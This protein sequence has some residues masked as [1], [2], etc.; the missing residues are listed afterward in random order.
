[1]NA[2]QATYEFG[3][4][5][6][7]GNKK[8]LWRD[9]EPVALTP[10][11][12]DTLLT[13]I[14]LRDRVVTK[15]ELLER[16]WRGTVVEEGGLARNISILRKALGEKPDQHTYIVTV[17]GKGY[18]FVADVREAAGAG[19][20]AKEARA[21]R[22]LLL[23]GLVALAAAVLVVYLWRH[24]PGAPAAPPAITS[25]AVLPLANLSGDPAQEYFADGMT[26]ALIGNLARIRALR[27]VSRTSVMRFKGGT[28]S[29]PEIARALSVDAIVEGSVLRT[30][31][32]VRISVQLIHVATD[33]HLWAREYERDLTDILKLQGEVSRAVAEEIQVQITAEERARLASVASVDPAAYQEYL[34]GQHYLWR[35]DEEDLTRAIDHFEQATRLDGRY[36]AA[37]AGLSH[38]WWWRGVWGAKSPKQVEVQS[39]AAALRALELDPQLAAAHVSTGRIKFSY[40]WDWSGAEMDFGRALELDPNSLDAHFF[41]GMLFM[42]LGRFPE[43]IA[44]IERAEQLDPLSATVQSAFGRIL[45]RARR[46]D[47]AILHLNQAIELQP[48]APGNYGRLADVY[49]EMGRY[50]EA[51]AVHEKEKRVSG[52]AQDLSPAVARIYARMG[53]ADEARRILDLQRT[54]GSQ[55][56]V[57]ATT[58][59]AL[60]DKDEAFR[61][62]FQVTEERDALNYVKTDPRLD[63][64][65]SDPR[66]Q[67]LLRRM[68][69]PTEPDGH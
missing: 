22:W 47:E 52:R 28:R 3:P 10:K 50:D 63:S 68:N 64:L 1:M 24:P 27:V 15:D 33:A 30:G 39:R 6:L 17:P 37:Y 41:E 9:S 5:C 62:L 67:T 60:G 45:Y 38:A 54:R 61:L 7:D 32:R 21:S 46:F 18:R 66:W 4:F 43:S 26:E 69:L 42:A 29:L 13:L 8:L 25:L 44:H 11:V 53:K 35:L 16:V 55:W 2:S 19:A 57:L 23:G 56:F 31:D 12:L 48:E 51:L 36:A 14:E 58:Y 59:A 40:D 49:E 20:S 65:H 34:L